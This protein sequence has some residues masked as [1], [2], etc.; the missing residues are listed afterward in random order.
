[1]DDHAASRASTQ[2]VV[3][4]SY[5]ATAVRVIRYDAPGY[6]SSARSVTTTTTIGQTGLATGEVGGDA[7]GNVNVE[8]STT[9]LCDAHADAM[10]VADESTGV[11]AG[12]SSSMVSGSGSR[13]RLSS[14]IIDTSLSAI[15]KEGIV[16]VVPAV[17]SREGVLCVEMRIRLYKDGAMSKLLE[18]L[19]NVSELSGLDSF[20]KYI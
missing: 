12:R 20:Y 3:Q 10:R 7:E 5:N 16:R 14:G 1:V 8:A 2:S 11:S 9:R 13:R 19:P 17:E 4:R 18:K 15:A 6:A